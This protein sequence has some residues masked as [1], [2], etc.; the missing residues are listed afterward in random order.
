MRTFKNIP[1]LDAI[2]IRMGRMPA[3][4]GAIVDLLQAPDGTYYAKSKPNPGLNGGSLDYRSPEPNE[5]LD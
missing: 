4:Y 2:D 1:L 3:G 5:G